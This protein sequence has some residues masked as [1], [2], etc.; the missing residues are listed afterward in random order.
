MAAN[1]SICYTQDRM[2]TAKKEVQE[3][4]ILSQKEVDKRLSKWL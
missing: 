1:K 2:K 4:R 3:G